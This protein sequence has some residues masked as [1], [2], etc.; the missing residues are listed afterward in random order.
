MAAFAED[1]DA[2]TTSHPQSQS[3]PTRR[4]TSTRQ[5]SHHTTHRPNSASLPLA[6][7]L[8]TPLPVVAPSSDID[9]AGP[10]RRYDEDEAVDPDKTFVAGSTPLQSP[11]RIHAGGAGV[12]AGLEVAPM[13]SPTASV[14][15]P[16]RLLASTGGHRHSRSPLR[17][18]H[19]QPSSLPNPAPDIITSVPSSTSFQPSLPPNILSLPSSTPAI[20]TKR[21]ITTVHMHDPDITMAG[22]GGNG[23]GGGRAK[24]SKRRNLG[25]GKQ[26]ED[27]AVEKGD[28]GEK[29]RGRKGKEG[30]GE[31]V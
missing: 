24:G 18:R 27:N 5:S 31:A 12:G 8:R 29:R 2:P 10:S 21:P 11:T 23:G 19:L 7:T 25:V 14:A 30:G 3:Q 20:G 15:G 13:S 22:D 16:S 28:K 4:P 17:Y 26:D 6:D 9:S 1:D